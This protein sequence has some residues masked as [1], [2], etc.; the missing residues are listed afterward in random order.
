[1]SQLLNPAHLE[2]VFHTRETTAVR[3]PH[4]TMK[5]S[6]CVL[7]LGKDHTKQQ[8]LAQPKFNKNAKNPEDLLTC[9]Q[10]KV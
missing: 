7:Q 2:P 10:K 3:S 8:G 1:M 4:T 9:Y 6:P 5:S